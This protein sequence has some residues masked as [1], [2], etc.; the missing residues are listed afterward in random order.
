MTAAISAFTTTVSAVASPIPPIAAS[1]SSIPP[2]VPT[3]ASTISTLAI[4]AA[5]VAAFTFLAADLHSTVL[6]AAFANLIAS[7]I[8]VLSPASAAFRGKI[9][10][11]E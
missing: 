8:A 6:V 7:A 4:S 5:A 3:I 1:I 2:T 9:G 10:D 11:A